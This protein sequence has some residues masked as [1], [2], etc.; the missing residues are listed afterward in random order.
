MRKAPSWFVKALK[1]LNPH[2]TVAWDEAQGLWAVRESVRSSALI[3]EID[4][5]PVYR[6][7]RRPET[8]L[9]FAGLG[10]RL[11]DHVR[12]NDPRRYSSVQQMVKKLRIDDRARPATL[13][14][15]F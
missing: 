14:A 2:F 15:Q 8:A 12:R 10:S 11:L 5:A 9:R 13:A 6:I 3:S 1:A 4:G 7:K